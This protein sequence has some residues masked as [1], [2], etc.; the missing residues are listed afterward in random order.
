MKELK[1]K[2]V[3][4][5]KQGEDSE[6]YKIFKSIVKS[7]KINVIVVKKGDR[8]KLDEKTKL[9]I[10]WPKEKQ[11]EENILNNNSIVAKLKWNSFS[12]LLTGDIEKIAEEQILQEYKNN[13]S[14][15]KSTVLKVGHHGSKTSSTFDFIKEISPEIGLIGVG[16]NNKF[17]HPNEEVINRLQEI[18]AKIYRTDNMGEIILSIT[19]ENKSKKTKIKTKIMLNENSAKTQ[20]RDT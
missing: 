10:L 15:L 5:S 13:L 17:G 6:N 2:N 16:E 12:L 11:I 3:I 1:V 18:G 7:K 19:I 14:I 9:D 20:K 4:I 8:L